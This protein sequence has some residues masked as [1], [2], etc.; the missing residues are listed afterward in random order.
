VAAWVLITP[1]GTEHVRDVYHEF[2]IAE[3]QLRPIIPGSP[4]SAVELHYEEHLAR[5][6]DQIAAEWQD[7]GILSRILREAKEA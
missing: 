5:R 2:T 6:Q 4:M 7:W 3:Q 1:D